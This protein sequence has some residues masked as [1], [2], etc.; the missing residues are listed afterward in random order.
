MRI[1]LKG[2]ESA[3][4]RTEKRHAKGET[5]RSGAVVKNLG[6]TLNILHLASV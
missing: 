1:L 4:E 2:T 3:I 6:A 5:V